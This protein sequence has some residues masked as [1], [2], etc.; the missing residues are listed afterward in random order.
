MPE[1]FKERK[2]QK[3]ENVFNL[4]QFLVESLMSSNKW[5]ELSQKDSLDE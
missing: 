2:D 1:V 3:N 4:E 5:D